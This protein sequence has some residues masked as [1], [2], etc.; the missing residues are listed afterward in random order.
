MENSL[1]FYF[2]F[3]EAI[4]GKRVPTIFAEAETFNTIAKGSN[5]AV[6]YPKC[7]IPILPRP[8]VIEGVLLND[9]K[10]MYPRQ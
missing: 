5:I 8:C 7:L 3:N 2:F 4:R 9:C 6:K 1:H 10:H